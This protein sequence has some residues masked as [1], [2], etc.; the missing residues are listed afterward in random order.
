LIAAKKK[1]TGKGLRTKFII[2]ILIPGILIWLIPY[3]LD[4]DLINERKWGPVIVPLMIA[5]IVGTAIH[6]FYL[7][8][9]ALMIFLEFPEDFESPAKK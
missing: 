4:H 6:F 9:Y 8:Y 1:Y 5:L 3:L 2:G 7:V